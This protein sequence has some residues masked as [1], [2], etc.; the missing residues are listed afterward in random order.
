[1]PEHL[2]PRRKRALF[3]AHHRGMVEND[4]LLGKWAEREIGGLSEEQVARFEALLDESDNDLF[5][6]ITG[7]RPL[8]PERDDDVMAAIRG[9]RQKLLDG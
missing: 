8:P 4:L 3:R 7:K 5:D 1:M 9:F 6:W 2:D